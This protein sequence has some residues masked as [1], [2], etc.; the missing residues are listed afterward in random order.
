MKKATYTINLNYTY[1][2]ERKGAKYTLDGTHY[3]NGGEFAEVV[4]K[5][6]LGY[7]AHKDACTAFDQDSDI[8]EIKAS[9][10]SSKASLTN[11]VLADTFE[12]SIRAYFQRTH[13]TCF[14]YTVIIDDEATLYMMNATEFELF[15]RKYSAL[16]ERGVIRF[17]ATSS[18]MVAFLEALA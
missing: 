6:V 15:I 12:D 17:K 14:I 16:N 10:K 11:M 8:P 18:K 4:T 9:V 13:S 3:M 5:S 2:A 1:E 7:E